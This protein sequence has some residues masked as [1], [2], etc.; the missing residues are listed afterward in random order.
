MTIQEAIKTK[1]PFRIKGKDGW[2]I[3]QWFEGGKGPFKN[4][5]DC[6]Y[7][8]HDGEFSTSIDLYADQ[9]LSNEWEI[10]K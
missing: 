5:V 4:L 6:D 8:T 1:K 10:V 7:F 9:V 3:S 2:E